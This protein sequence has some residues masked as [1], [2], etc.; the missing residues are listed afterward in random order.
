MKTPLIFNIGM[1]KTG[2]NSLSTAL[3]RLGISCLR[4]GRV[5]QAFDRNQRSGRLC[6][7]SLPV[8]YQ[9]FVDNPIP[10]IF[11]QLDRDY[12]GSR[13]IV[14]V[15]NSEAWIKSRMNHF[16]GSAMGQ[17]AEYAR[18]ERRMEAHF[19]ERQKDMLWYDIC[20]GDGWEPL[21]EFLGLPVPNRGFP[22]KNRTTPQKIR[23]RRRQRK[24][25]HK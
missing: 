12:P 22:F 25:R 19:G 6:L 9:A 1:N 2:T 8:K 17:A 23:Q 7:H 20:G 11:E 13:F 14:T 21:C 24:R 3:A 4:G 16:G 18:W 5:K 10:Y 15:R